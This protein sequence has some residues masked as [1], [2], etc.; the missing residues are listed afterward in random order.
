MNFIGTHWGNT[1][2]GFRLK[3]LGGNSRWHILAPMSLSMRC[4]AVIPCLN[5]AATISEVVLAVRRH[6]SAV[7]VIDDGSQDNTGVLAKKAG[8]EVLRHDTPR[9]K[10]IALQTGWQR[11]RERGFNWALAMDGDGQHSA[12][13]IPAFLDAA[14]RTGAELVVGNRMDNPNGMPWLR[15][16]VNRW[17]SK[18]ISKLAGLRL[19]DSQCGFRLMNLKTWSKLPV[20]AARFEIESDVLLE[21]AAHKRSIQ[22][23]PIRVIYQAEQSKIHPVHDTIRWFRW[24]W[25]ARRLVGD[26]QKLNTS[27]K[28]ILTVSQELQQG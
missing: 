14:E 23:V 12:E 10:G 28:P 4:A 9:G 7:L 17:M 13:D 6:I 27:A 16:N 26:R 11:A 5:E 1:L 21:F 24:W 18:R 20:T 15:R 3:E 25:R 19:P 2:H 8:A 22:F